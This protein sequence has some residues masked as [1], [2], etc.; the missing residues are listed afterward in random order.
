MVS[1][2]ASL[3]T[4]VPYAMTAYLILRSFHTAYRVV[5]LP[6]A[7]AFI[8]WSVSVFVRVMLSSAVV[9]VLLALQPTYMYPSLSGVV[10]VPVVG[11]F[12]ALYVIVLVVMALPFVSVP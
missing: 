6:S 5:V 8:H 9:A 12:L 10:Y 7:L 3:S 1:P 4:P 11:W 2:F